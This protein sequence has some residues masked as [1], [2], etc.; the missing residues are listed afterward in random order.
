[1]AA[2]ARC[3]GR[4]VCLAEHP[5]RKVVTDNLDNFSN[6][7]DSHRLSIP[8]IPQDEATLTLSL[9]PTLPCSEVIAVTEVIGYLRSHPSK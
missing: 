4:N 9:A 1:M 2:G 5:L 3:G 6:R 8:S 7:G